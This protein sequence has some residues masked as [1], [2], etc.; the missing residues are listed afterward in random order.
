[1]KDTHIQAINEGTSDKPSCSPR[2]CP[3]FIKCSAPV[4]PLDDSPYKRVLLKEDPTCFYLTESVK[5]GAETRFKG[6]GLEWLYKKV[7]RATP[8]LISRYPRI[9]DALKR[10]MHSSSRMDRRVPTKKIK[11]GVTA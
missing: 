4:C 6:A 9:C 3:R 7:V 1:M 11:T 10:A 5:D 2:S 8:H